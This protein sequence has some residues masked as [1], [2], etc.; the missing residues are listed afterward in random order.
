MTGAS[1][2]HNLI[3]TNLIANV[4]NFLEEKPCTIYP[5]NLRIWVEKANSYFYPDATIIVEI[6]NFLIIKKIP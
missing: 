1:L 3:L 6:Q 2:A 5:N 4:G